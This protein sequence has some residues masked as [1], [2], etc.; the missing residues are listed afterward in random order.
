MLWQHLSPRL[1]EWP[2]IYFDGELNYGT[3]LVV[4]SE[5]YA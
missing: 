2:A 4:R 5:Y 3:Y 1:T